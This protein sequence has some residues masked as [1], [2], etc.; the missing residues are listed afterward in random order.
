MKVGSYW[1]APG[2]CGIAAKSAAIRDTPTV[3]A[4]S[5]ARQHVTH[6]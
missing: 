6:S 4:V 5:S 1:P 2:D 3:I